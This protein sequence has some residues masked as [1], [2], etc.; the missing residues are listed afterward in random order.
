M[1]GNFAAGSLF[2]RGILNPLINLS[3]EEEQK[4]LTTSKLC[5]NIYISRVSQRNLFQV[6]CWL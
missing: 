3:I 5:S 1:K 4:V 2:A 6:N